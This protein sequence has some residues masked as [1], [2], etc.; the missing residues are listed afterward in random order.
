MLGREPC[1]KPILQYVR[2]GTGLGVASGS[3][4]DGGNPGNQA[5]A[6]NR[7]CFRDGHFE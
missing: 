2:S 4:A 6:R 1:Y 7:H 5:I 3:D